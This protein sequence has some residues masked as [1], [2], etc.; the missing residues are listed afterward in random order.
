MMSHEKFYDSDFQR[1]LR[2]FEAQKQ[3]KSELAKQAVVYVK[4]ETKNKCYHPYTIRSDGWKICV[5][6]GLCLRRI[7]TFLRDEVF[8]DSVLL[9]KKEPNRVKEMRD[10]FSKMLVS[11]PF[12]T[13]YFEELCSVCKRY[14]DLNDSTNK[15]STRFRIKSL[16]AAVLWTKVKELDTKMTIDEFSERC[17]VS[18]YTISKINFN[19]WPV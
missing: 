3:I 17:G 5:T 9:R 14:S 2:E 4:G 7:S 8:Y 12:V 13:K 1:A 19:T 16:C 10:I 6:C 11:F 18:K 15:L